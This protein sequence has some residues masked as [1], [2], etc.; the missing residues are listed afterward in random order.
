MNMAREL[1]RGPRQRRERRLDPTRAGIVSAAVESTDLHEAL[2]HGRH[3][4][5]MAARPRSHPHG[6]DTR[7]VGGV[8]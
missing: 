7:T 1:A 4:L 8:V 3:D 6:A 5:D 2:V